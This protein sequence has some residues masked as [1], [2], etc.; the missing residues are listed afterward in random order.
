V[1]TAW[2]DDG[3]VMAVEHRTRPVYGVQFHPEAILTEAGQLLI[4]NFCRTLS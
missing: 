2:T 1:S 4:N 3:L